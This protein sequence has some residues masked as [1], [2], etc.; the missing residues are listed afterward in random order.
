MDKLTP[1]LTQN[2]ALLVDVIKQINEWD[3]N[4]FKQ[5]WLRIMTPAMTALRHQ[6]RKVAASLYPEYENQA[7]VV[8]E[9]ISHTYRT[10][11]G[12][13]EKGTPI[14]D[15]L[16]RAQRE[17]RNV[18]NEQDILIE[19]CN[20]TKSF[21]KT[22]KEDLATLYEMLPQV[23]VTAKQI[24][25]IKSEF[26]R[27]YMM[28]SLN[29]AN[30]D[31]LYDQLVQ[32]WQPIMF[33]I[34]DVEQQTDDTA[35]AVWKYHHDIKSI[36]QD[37]GRLLDRGDFKSILARLETL[38]KA[39]DGLMDEL[40]VGRSVRRVLLAQR[41]VDI[42][43]NRVKALGNEVQHLREK[44]WRRAKIACENLEFV[45]PHMQRSLDRAPGDDPFKSDDVYLNYQDL[46]TALRRWKAFT[47][48]GKAWQDDPDYQTINDAY[49]RATALPDTSVH[50]I[51]AYAQTM[52][53]C[54][55]ALIKKITLDVQG[56]VR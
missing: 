21:Q 45:L 11:I 3:G 41:A 14:R 27:L 18:I 6:P 9:M 17:L 15:A 32:A 31:K 40:Y 22:I 7:Q 53:K 1:V 47:Q 28:N 10:I 38:T 4:D 49:E 24:A 50:A 12:A 52:C 30:A 55:P 5:G 33:D 8:V 54:L 23:K 36:Y 44:A 39:L 29:T 37:I 34:D 16:Q 26:N 25:G 51:T 13:V 56:G 48:L 20:P 46:R 42:R 2:R 19:L 43:R 35:H